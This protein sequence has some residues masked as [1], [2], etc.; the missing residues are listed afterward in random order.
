MS[1]PSLLIESTDSMIIGIDDIKDI[2]G[3]KNTIF[4]PCSC[5]FG[6]AWPVFAQSQLLSQCMQPMSF[7]SSRVDFTSCL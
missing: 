2:E 1:V 4:D 3:C 6:Q 5:S 7:S